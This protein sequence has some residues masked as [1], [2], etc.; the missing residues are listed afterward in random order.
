LGKNLPSKCRERFDERKK[1]QLFVELSKG[2]C[3]QDS[4]EGG[5]SMVEVTVVL[6]V[7]LIIAAIA[8]PNMIQA[9]YD[10]QLRGSASQV[11]DLMQQA[12][13]LAAK[14]NATYSVRFQIANGVQ[15]AYIDRNNNGVL[16]AGEPYIDLG[17][18]IV[19]AAGA[20]GGNGQPTP[21]ALPGD[22]S[23]GNPCDN[24]CVIAFSPRGLP[25][26]YTTPPTCT[27]PAASYFVYYF[28]DARPNGWSAVAITK[29]GRSK[30]LLWNGAIWR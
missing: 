22:T 6:L 20:P 3:Q 5:F 9:W 27:T 17:R 26:N 15:R 24:T 13:M 28:Q 1:V 11:A 12:R 4:S 21:Y 30:A 16:D 25:C 10:I 23:V 18:Q 7:V 29:A 8:L 19:S 2:R 14:N